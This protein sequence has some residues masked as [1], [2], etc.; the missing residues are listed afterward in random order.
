M[1]KR[2]SLKRIITIAAALTWFT[3]AHQAPAVDAPR[4][5]E[6]VAKRFGYSPAEITLKKGDPVVLT[7]RSEDVTHGL[8]FEELNLQTEVNKGESVDLTFTPTQAG[9][10]LAHCSHFCGAG[11]GGMTLA[12]HVTE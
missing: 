7:L 1:I 8:K 4:R 12:V 5:I 3:L 9:D 2:V 6:I 11:H 10:F